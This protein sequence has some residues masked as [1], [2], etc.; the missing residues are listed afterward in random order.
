MHDINGQF[1]SFAS[2]LGAFAL[3]IL[4]FFEHRKTVRPSSPVI[5]YVTLSA[6]N[7]FVVLTMPSGNLGTASR[8]LMIIRLSL[9][10]SLLVTESQSKIAILEPPYRLFAPEELTGLL[11]RA[12]FWWINPILKEG[13]YGFLK[14]DDLP[15]VDRA[16]SSSL[17]RKRSIRAWN[18]RCK[19]PI[20]L[21]FAKVGN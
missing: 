17:L 12:L 20:T 3:S 15:K 16:L 6:I 14:Q 4:S 11:G 21:D 2:T 8:I 9:E 5:I 19:S 1:L 13:Y 18:Q 7:H 10:L